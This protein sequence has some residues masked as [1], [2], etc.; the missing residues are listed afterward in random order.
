MPDASVRAGPTEEPDMVTILHRPWLR[1]LAL[2]A[3]LALVPA[4]VA[5]PPLLCHPFDTAGARS[6]PWGGGGWR[7]LRAD[8][9]VRQL[10][11]DTEALLGADTPVIARME[12]LRR[13]AIYASRDGKVAGNL[14]GR[15]EARVKRAGGVQSRAMARF[16]LGYFDETLEEVVRLQG[17]DMPGI[18]RVDV[19][20]LRAL[21]S[22]IDGGAEVEAVLALRPRDPALRFAA[23]LIA[24][25]DERRGD[26]VAHARA[27]RAGASADRLV[28]LN[29][30]Q[31]SN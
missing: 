10:A 4:A 27:A 11:S 21:S 16:D 9:D 12:T 18:G 17:Y 13:A 5:G 28:A 15:L 26:Y 6:L 23:A 29:L 30:G 20:G 8:Y 25:A 1:G 22:R 2:V 14:L 19:S 31:I 24:A 3:T 7:D